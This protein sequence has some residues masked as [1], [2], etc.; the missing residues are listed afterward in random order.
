MADKS[1][2]IIAGS[3]CNARA[4]LQRDLAV[5]HD[6][7]LSARAVVTAVTAQTDAKVSAVHMIPPEIIEQQ[8]T[9][10][11]EQAPPDSVKIGMMGT[12]ETVEIIARLLANLSCP[13]VVDPVI[14]TS[15]GH[16]LLTESG[17]KALKHKLFSISSLITPN[18]PE[19]KHLL[20]ESLLPQTNAPAELAQALYAEGGPA[21][22]LKG[23]HDSGENC[24]DILR[25]GAETHSFCAPRFAKGRRGTGCTLST[26]IACHLANGVTLYSACERAVIQTRKWI[27]QA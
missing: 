24:C 17:I 6:M 10:V 21:V 15:S 26:S 7:G 19:A 14:A 4:G 23:G 2:L 12:A 25:N 11:L 18:L 20:G 3:D 8:L 13:I 5:A 9:A 1:V 27:S 16:E 22:L